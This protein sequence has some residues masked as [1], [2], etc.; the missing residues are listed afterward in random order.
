MVSIFLSKTA[1]AKKDI[2]AE[3][4]VY[5][6]NENIPLD[7]SLDLSLDVEGFQSNVTA[8][9]LFN[10]ETD[11]DYELKFIAKEEYVTSS[12]S[13]YHKRYAMEGNL[14]F[15]DNYYQD[16]L[17]QKD[18]MIKKRSY[19]VTCDEFSDYT[20]LTISSLVD[21]DETK[22]HFITSSEGINHEIYNVHT[23]TNWVRKDELFDLY[24]IG[25]DVGEIDW[26]IYKNSRLL[27]EVEGTVELV[28]EEEVSFGELLLSDCPS[29]IDSVDWFNNKMFLLQNDQNYSTSFDELD[30]KEKI[31]SY[32]IFDL[33]IAA[34]KQLSHEIQFVL[35][36]E[37]DDSYTPELLCFKFN[38]AHLNKFSTAK[39]NLTISSDFYLINPNFSYSKNENQYQSQITDFDKELVVSLSSSAN[40][41]PNV[42][43]LELSIK[44]IV[45]AIALIVLIALFIFPKRIRRNYYINDFQLRPRVE[46]I[47]R[48]QNVLA[49]IAIIL[50]L[51][52]MHYRS[53]FSD[54]ALAV[55]F[56]A[57]IIALV[58]HFKYC[59]HNAVGLISLSLAITSNA[60]LLYQSQ[61]VFEINTVIVTICI[62]IYGANNLIIYNDVEK[63]KDEEYYFL[64]LDFMSKK[65]L[66]CYLL[67]VFVIM[68][69]GMAILVFAFKITYILIISIINLIL[70]VFYR[71]IKVVLV[72]YRPLHKYYKNLDYQSLKY[73]MEVRLSNDNIHPKTYNGYL[74]RLAEISLANDFDDYIKYLSSFKAMN[75][76]AEQVD[77]DCLRLNYLLSRREFFSLYQELRIKYA[78]YPNLLNKVHKRYNYW[79]PYYNGEV[80]ES[81][82]LQYPYRTKNNWKNARNLF[83]QINHYVSRNNYGKARELGR[84]FKRQYP[85]LKLFIG[86]INH[87]NLNRI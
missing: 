54:I 74:L 87:L 25:D 5:F 27:Q 50:A 12:S 40:P 66:T 68:F 29:E 55:V 71:V 70:V 23:I 31:Q 32:F 36:S 11:S 44:V 18:M 16:N 26:K 13:E 77:F 24:I 86:S 59:I 37:V 4:I 65:A 63:N 33:D 43:M 76:K 85:S 7:V 35:K 15:N 82:V 30:L 49:V 28:S 61:N 75:N 10:N 45:S 52:G 47:Y 81:I 22:T 42:D 83:I 46:R 9:Y 17:Y 2:A 39:I 56:T 67:F 78:D 34:N 21:F 14:V 80:G 64:P 6:L 73:K 57:F 41:E 51:I 48:G 72:D 62:L 3:E 84:L 58:A 79:L 53:W 60:N 1:Y 20:S 8:N 69:T 19:K 38:F